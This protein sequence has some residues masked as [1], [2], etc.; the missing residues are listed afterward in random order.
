VKK[1]PSA[2][3]SPRHQLIASPFHDDA[4][5]IVRRIPVTQSYSIL[6]IWYFAVL[7]TKPTTSVLSRLAACTLI[8]IF[9]IRQNGSASPK[10]ETCLDM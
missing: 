1:L 6:R 4:A 9:L 10:T 2:F 7:T 8:G 5:Q 3:I